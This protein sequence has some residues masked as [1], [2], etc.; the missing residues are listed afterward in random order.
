[1]IEKTGFLHFLSAKMYKK[2]AKKKKVN[3]ILTFYIQ[4]K[5]NDKLLRT[6]IMI[7]SVISK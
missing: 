7:M 4:F 6:K 2:Q 3:V 5:S 1:M